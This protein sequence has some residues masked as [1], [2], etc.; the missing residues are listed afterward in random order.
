MERRRSL[1]TGKFVR[2]ARFRVFS[3]R[4]EK[5]PQRKRFDRVDQVQKKKKKKIP[6]PLRDD[7]TVECS[8][9]RGRDGTNTK[10]RWKRNGKLRWTFRHHKRED[11]VIK[12]A[13]LIQRGPKSFAPWP[14]TYY[15][16]VRMVGKC[17]SKQETG[18]IE[19]DKKQEKGNGRSR[20]KRN[21]E[22]GKVMWPG[23]NKVF[24]GQ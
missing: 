11:V 18:G 21:R 16:L 4:M 7:R 9:A 14:G 19:I 13:E 3:H 8:L 15:S 20:R 23:W 22:S 5:V 17:A 1:S 2:V 6:R 12:Q 10:T 24:P